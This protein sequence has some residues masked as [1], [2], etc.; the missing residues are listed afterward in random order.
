MA[1]TATA[2]DNWDAD[3]YAKNASFVPQMTGDI[4]GWFNEAAQGEAKAVV[5]LGCGDG[6]LTLALFKSRL[7]SSTPFKLLLALDASPNMIAS[8]QSKIDADPVLAQAASKGKLVARVLDGQDIQ[9]EALTELLALNGGDRYDA[10]FS[11]AAMHWMKRDPVAVI[12]GV[13]S[14]L[15]PTAPLI[16]EFGGHLNV[17]SVHA[18]LLAALRR[19]GIADPERTVSPWF[20]PTS[21][22]YTAMLEKEG[23]KVERCQQ[24]PRITPLPTGVAGWLDTFG[25]PFFQPILS[26]SGPA[27]VARVKQEVVDEMRDVLR[28]PVSGDWFIMYVRLRVLAWRGE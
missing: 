13:K 24:V 26:T 11:N 10:V 28:D 18:S 5:D 15:K 20:F 1:L 6:V 4:V 16:S 19:R 8:F 9:G 17:S 21:A 2:G 27:E 14:L 22:T 23:F 25:A 3:T 12:K 7:A